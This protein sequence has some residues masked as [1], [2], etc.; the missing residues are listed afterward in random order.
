MRLKSI[1]FDSTEGEFVID[2]PTV[3]AKSFTGAERK[4]KGKNVIA[5]VK[6]DDNKFL[7]FVED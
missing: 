7:V 3:E 6:I 1:T 4:M 2:T 5:M